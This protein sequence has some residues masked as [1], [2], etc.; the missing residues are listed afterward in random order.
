ML[1]TACKISAIRIVNPPDRRPGGGPC[2]FPVFLVPRCGPGNPCVAIFGGGQA[3]LN[4]F[5]LRGAPIFIGPQISAAFTD[6]F[7]A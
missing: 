5:I 7:A 2:F 6:W 1:S 4:G 3:P